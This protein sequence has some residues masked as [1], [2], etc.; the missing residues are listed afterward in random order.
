MA[1]IAAF[2]LFPSC[3]SLICV[4]ALHSVLSNTM[5]SMKSV[6]YHQIHIVRGNNS[7]KSLF[8]FLKNERLLKLK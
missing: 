2:G 6:N 3:I 5:F 8:F 4:G 7:S 1:L